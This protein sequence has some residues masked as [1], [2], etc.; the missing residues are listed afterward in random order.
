LKP[1]DKSGE[2][3][4]A[5]NG[6]T[7]LPVPGDLAELLIS[8]RSEYDLTQAKIDSIGEFRFKVKGWSITLQTALL[9]ALFSERGIRLQGFIPLIVAV[10]GL[11]IIFAF[12]CL[13]YH[14]KILG[15]ALGR[16]ASDIEKLLD[17]VTNDYTWSGR[18]RASLYRSALSD[19][20]GTPRIASV[21]PPALQDSIWKTLD[22]MMAL[23]L[24]AFYYFQYVFTAL[25]T[26]CAQLCY[27][28]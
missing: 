28:K 11:S 23:R 10:F 22:N 21:M 13:E 16:R 18:K 17:V 25:A 5:V 19:I 26:C 2:G 7:G 4:D 20:K 1:I 15:S 8:L 3:M 27:V 9:I 6:V 12:H 24:N 14:Q